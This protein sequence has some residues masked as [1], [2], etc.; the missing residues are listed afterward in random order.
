MAAFALQRQSW[1][2]VT[3]M[4]FASD[5]DSCPFLSWGFIFRREGSR[6]SR[7]QDASGTVEGGVPS[8][9][10]WHTHVEAQG[11][12]LPQRGSQDQALGLCFQAGDGKALPRESDEHRRKD[13]ASS[14]PVKPRLTSPICASRA[15][16]QFFS[17]HSGKWAKGTRR[18][19]NPLAWKTEGKTGGEK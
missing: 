12:F 1:A 18:V 10:S 19:R 4:V 8:R 2:V 14:R 13:P 3:E 7:L 17:F 5:L 15:A 6:V 9:G 16:S 11:A